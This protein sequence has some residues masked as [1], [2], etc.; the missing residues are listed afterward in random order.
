[1]QIKK[2]KRERDKDGEVCDDYIDDEG[3]TADAFHSRNL[4]TNKIH[5][6]IHYLVSY[7]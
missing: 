4:I 1:M 3:G 6:Y 5:Y 7:F 2:K